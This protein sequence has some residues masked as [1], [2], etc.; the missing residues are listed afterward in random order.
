MIHSVE[1]FKEVTA[2]GKIHCL[3]VGILTGG[4]DRSVLGS[5]VKVVYSEVKMSKVKL[6]IFVL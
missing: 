6:G 3:L 5:T 4:K 1:Y 2:N